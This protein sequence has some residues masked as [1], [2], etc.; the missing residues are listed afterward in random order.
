MCCCHG[1]PVLFPT[2]CPMW[3]P[4]SVPMGLTP[5]CQLLPSPLGWVEAGHNHSGQ[6]A[7]GEQGNSGKPSVVGMGALSSI[8]CFCEENHLCRSCCECWSCSA[9]VLP[10]AGLI[11]GCAC[12]DGCSKTPCHHPVTATPWGRKGREELEM[13][14]IGKA[15]KHCPR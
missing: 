14:A 15:I 13:W 3:C 1:Q 4:S 6:R 12:T 11:P 2:S 9:D 5:V 10:C 8:C 7:H